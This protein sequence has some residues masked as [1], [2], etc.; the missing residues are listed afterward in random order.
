MRRVNEQKNHKYLG[1][2]WLRALLPLVLLLIVL[3]AVGGSGRVPGYWSVLGA[4]LLGL[5][6]FIAGG[7]WWKV[8]ST[9][10]A[11][12]RAL[13]S[14]TP[15]AA[16]ELVDQSFQ[17]ATIADSDAFRAQS[18]ATLLALY[19]EGERA[20]DA[21]RPIDWERRAPL[22]RAA[23]IV[24]ES[25]IALI[26][27]GDFEG[28]LRE[29]TRARSLAGVKAGTPGGKTSNRLYASVVAFAQ[30]LADKEDASTLPT[31]EASAKAKLFPKLQAIAVAGLAAH[32][33]RTGTTDRF[34]EL[35]SQLVAIAPKLDEVFFGAAST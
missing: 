2:L 31:L 1:G 13:R 12:A 32:A 35:R 20:R 24:S 8:R 14:P 16:L 30:V 3:V 29:A 21:L 15:D 9:A 27:D 33:H 25:L 19:G 4:G 18:R 26:C 7:V 23:G 34:N 11:M 5:I 10:G 6:G 28:G 22:I 17:K